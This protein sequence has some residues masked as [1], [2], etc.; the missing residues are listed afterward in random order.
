MKDLDTVSRSTA[1]APGEP[2]EASARAVEQVELL[3]T[4]R[5]GDGIERGVELVE[6]AAAQHRPDSVSGQPGQHDL[7]PRDAQVRRHL[8][9]RGITSGVPLEIGRASCRERA[10]ISVGVGSGKWTMR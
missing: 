1:A 6:L 8:V 9:Q 7:A 3:G 5:L 2:R 10:E 4:G